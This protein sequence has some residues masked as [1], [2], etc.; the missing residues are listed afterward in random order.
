[1]GSFNVGTTPTGIAFDGSNIWI[2]NQGMNTVMKLSSAGSVIA[3]FASGVGPV[4]VAFDGANMWI[5]NAG[6]ATL[7]K[8]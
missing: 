4:G 3:T 6:E 5:A 8:M 7:S 2:A 1:M